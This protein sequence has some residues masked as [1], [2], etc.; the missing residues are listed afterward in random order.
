MLTDVHNYVA[1][2]DVRIM[3]DMNL[4]A[5]RFSM[6]WSRVLPSKHLVAVYAEAKPMACV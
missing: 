4:D 3:K 1:Q 2:E 5:Y 6:S